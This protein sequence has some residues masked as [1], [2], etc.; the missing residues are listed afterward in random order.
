MRKDHVKLCKGVSND[1][2]YHVV[3]NYDAGMSAFI[4]YHQN[5]ES[6]SPS[7]LPQPICVS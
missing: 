3:I 6:C 7:P 5:G 2:Q 1:S 4:S